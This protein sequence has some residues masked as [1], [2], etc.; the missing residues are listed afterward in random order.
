MIGTMQSM[1]EALARRAEDEGKAQL[2]KL[3]RAA[4]DGDREREAGWVLTG[5]EEFPQLLSHL[6]EA[7][8]EN[9]EYGAYHICSVCS[10]IVENQRP[11]RCAVC[12]SKTL[13]EV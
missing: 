7:Q 5:V 9:I 1:R 3:F 10:Y 13:Y 12:G 11:D 4:T 8:F 6:D 2:A